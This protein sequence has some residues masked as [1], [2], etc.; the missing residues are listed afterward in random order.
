MSTS[1]DMATQ[2]PEDLPTPAS[3][4]VTAEIDAWVALPARA[5]NLMVAST[6]AGFGLPLSGAAVAL[7]VA[8]SHTEFRLAVFLLP[9]LGIAFGAWLG[10]KRYRHT[11][12]KHDGIGFAMRRGRL[13]QSETRVPGSRVQ[14]ID[15]KRGPLQRRLQLATLVIHT[16]G[17]QHSAVSLACLDEGDA[18]RLRDALARQT[19]ADDD[20]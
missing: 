2:P 7:F 20:D 1:G 10:N 11:A 3:V 9:L 16:A 5:R 4:D 19:N 14:H 6:A 12:W 15:I 13:W 18:E 17:T 8:A